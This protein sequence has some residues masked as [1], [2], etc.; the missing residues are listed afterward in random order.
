MSAAPPPGSVF[1]ELSS[2]FVARHPGDAANYLE[3]QDP[4]TAAAALETVPATS[5]ATLW[6]Y[7]S[8]G[9]GALVFPNVSPDIRKTLLET[10]DRMRATRVLAALPDEARERELALLDPAIA[11]EIRQ[12]LAF[13]ENTAGRVM[14][15]QVFSLRGSMTAE[16]ALNLLR[17]RG[18]GELVTIKIVD[19]SN[20]LTGLVDIRDL[21]LAP[22]ETLLSEIAAAVP[23]VVNPMDP[24]SLVVE[25]FEEFNL[26]EIAVVDL[27]GQVVG[28]IRHSQLVDALRKDA[29][30]DM[31]T[32]VGASADER[33]LSTS[34]FAIRKRLPWLQI[35]LLTAFLAASVVG[36]F[37]PTIAKYTAL[38]ILLPVV[39]GQSG[40]A[41]AQALA[42]TM[43]AIALR[44]IH[45]SQWFRVMRKEANAGFWNGI[46]IAI[47]CAIG[48]YVWSGNVALVLVIAASMVI[49]MVMAGIAGALVPITLARLKQDPA[50]ASSII[51]TTITDIAGFFSFL[52]IATLLM[53]M[54]GT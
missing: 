34:W 39:A 41:G 52:G 37:E 4:K 43:R 16:K 44:E 42:V 1:A 20:R 21:A 48:V 22:T 30:L 54:F 9:Y 13:P 50:V 25:R 11:G 28:V 15:P 7:L 14:D 47:T 2:R 31:Q 18:R 10:L 53:G 46:G 32:M 33:A 26:Q 36:I 29:S 24:R 45:F 17:Q 49:S 19:G 6:E 38:A 40:N 3:S 5:L 23:A 51:L 27:D 35:N 12:L 8:S